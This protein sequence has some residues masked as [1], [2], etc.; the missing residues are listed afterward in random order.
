MAFRPISEAAHRWSYDNTKCI[1]AREDSAFHPAGDAKSSISFAVVTAGIANE[2]VPVQ[3]AQ[4]WF[5][6]L[7]ISNAKI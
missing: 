5:H 7:A 3:L 4:C 1:V 6:G 2:S